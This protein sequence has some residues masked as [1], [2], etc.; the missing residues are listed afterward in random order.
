MLVVHL[1]WCLLLALGTSASSRVLMSRG[2]L[3]TT[4]LF[5]LGDVV[6]G[7]L[8][9]ALFCGV[10]ILPAVVAPGVL[11]G[12]HDEGILGLVLL[13]VVRPWC[14]GRSRL[15]WLPRVLLLKRVGFLPLLGRT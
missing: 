11:L 6:K 2:L 3:L 14:R 5:V 12:R 1:T 10:A 8:V 9:E 15:S 4:V 7:L 13:L